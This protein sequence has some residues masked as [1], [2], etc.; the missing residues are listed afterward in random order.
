MNWIIIGLSFIGVLFFAVPEMLVDTTL[1]NKN[2]SAISANALIT[3]TA[4]QVEQSQ[5]LMR[6]QSEADAIKKQQVELKNKQTDKKK[7]VNKNELI[8]GEQ[9]F[10]LL[11]IFNQA[12][13]VFVLIKNNQQQLVKAQVGDTL[14]GD[15][16]LI[17]ITNNTITLAN[18][19]QSKEFK[20]FLRQS[21]DKTSS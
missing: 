1:Q 17:A 9:V 16:K 4:Q 5:L 13:Q 20:L 18:A 2:N 11:G 3:P 7:I 6:L 12:E 14:S 19:Q 21:N 15:V 10:L 8:F